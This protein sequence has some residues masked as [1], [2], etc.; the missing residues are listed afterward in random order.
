MLSSGIEP[1]LSV[2]HRIV[3][4]LVQ[5]VAGR[6]FCQ[7]RCHADIA[8]VQLKQFDMLLGLVGTQHQAEW[9]AL[10]RLLLVFLQPTVDETDP[11][12]ASVPRA[13]RSTA[14][15]PVPTRNSGSRQSSFSLADD[16]SSSIRIV[17]RLLRA[18]P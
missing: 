16:R 11:L 4:P 15:S 12:Q 3:Q 2:T 14:F 13:D 1:R 8:I 6:K 5:D 7:I 18:W 9:R 17:T 10:T